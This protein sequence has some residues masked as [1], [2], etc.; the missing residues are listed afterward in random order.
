MPTLTPKQR[1]FLQVLIRLLRKNDVAPTVRELQEAAKL[2]SSRS[3]VQYLD[4]LE[5][6]GVISRG[7]GRRNIRIVARPETTSTILVPVIGRVAA[8]T[9]ILA[10][11]NV[12]DVIGVDR[13]VARGNHS[14]Y[15]LEVVGDSMDRAGIQNGDFVLVRYQETADDNATVIALIDDSATVKKLRLSRDAAILQPVSSN[16]VHR[17]IVVDPAF[18]IQG[19]VV[20]TFPKEQLFS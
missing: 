20:A 13:S 19:V 8:G 12:R 4:A 3:V 9:P 15:F 14:Y 7:E 10:K 1:S 16:P 6:A 17:P 2:R 11:E 18:R 5:S